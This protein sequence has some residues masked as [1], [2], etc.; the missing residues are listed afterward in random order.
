MCA[1]SAACSGVCGSVQEEATLNAV[2]RARELSSVSK[3]TLTGEDQ[4]GDMMIISMRMIL[5]M[6]MMM[7]MMTKMVVFAHYHK[8]L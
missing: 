3:K 7:V 2:E 6:V 8:R 5:R 4:P 1:L